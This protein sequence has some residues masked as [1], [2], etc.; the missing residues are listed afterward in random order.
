MNANITKI[1]L[2]T[3]MEV[4]DISKTMIYNL[5][6]EQV[7]TPFYFRGSSTKPYFDIQQ[8]E[9]ALRPEPNGGTKRKKT[10]S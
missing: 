1:P 2:K 4:Y 8:I 3:A 5:I 9:A 6:D 7:L 10:T